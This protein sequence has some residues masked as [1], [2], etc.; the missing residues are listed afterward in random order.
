MPRVIGALCVAPDA[1][2]QVR[3]T[4]WPATNPSIALWRSF[5]FATETP[6]MPVIR[7][8]AASPVF[9]AG[10]FGSTTLTH[11]PVLATEVEQLGW[12]TGCAVETSTPRRAA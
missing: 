2:I 5:W 3:V 11:A 4:F 1:S 12:P 6:P 7:P 9:E 8:Q 10:L